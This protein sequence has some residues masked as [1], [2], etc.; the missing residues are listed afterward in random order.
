MTYHTVRYSTREAVEHLADEVLRRHNI[1]TP[2]VDVDRIAEREGL[3]FEETAFTSASGAYYRID[4]HHGRALIAKNEWPLRR[5]F[6]KAHELAHHL[7]DTPTQ[8]WVAGTRLP[9]PSGYRG[10]ARHDAHEFFAA[11]LLVPRAWLGD[12]MR[13]R[14][15][16]LE[17]GPL[18]ADVARRF[19]VS[20]SAAEVRLKELG[21]I[22]G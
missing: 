21:H 2:P 11:C 5:P 22:G 7:M 13:S 16:R 10:R 20:K 3:V 6:T 8:N 19:G 15:W 4:E 18:I 12:Y 17:R 14:G 1:T 9:L